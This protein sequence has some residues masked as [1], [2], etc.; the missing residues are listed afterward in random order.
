MNAKINRFIGAVG[1]T[2]ALVALGVFGGTGPATAGTVEAVP[3]GSTSFDGTNCTAKFVR[4][5]S[6]III[7]TD[8]A[9]TGSQNPWASADVWLQFRPTLGKVPNPTCAANTVVAPFLFST[10]ETG[11][12]QWFVSDQVY[13]VCVY[14]VNDVVATGVVDSASAVTTAVTLP[15]AG[16]YR[17]DVS[18]TWQNGS[19][20]AQDAEFTTEDAWATYVDGY[21][22]HG[23]LLGEGFGDLQ[24]NGGFV[25]WGAYSSAHTYSV[26]MPGLASLDLGVFDGDSNTNIKDAGWY[27]DNVGSLSYTVTFLG[28]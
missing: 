6:G 9:C 10:S 8:R 3:A 11:L 24:V 26:T 15:L 2:A 18:G 23:Y 17:I 5:A 1:T 20:S 19:V 21:D 27:G 16:T 4:S 7:E 12:S 25:N 22:L 14:L 28:L 13:N